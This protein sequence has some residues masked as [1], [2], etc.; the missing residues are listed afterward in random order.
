MNHSVRFFSLVLLFLLIVVSGFS[1]KHTRGIV[2]DSISLKTLP[3]VHV[4]FKNK[5][6]GTTT[7]AQGVFNL[8]T[9]P[10][11]TLI[12]TY[13]GFNTLELPLLFEEED[14]LIRISEKAI[15]LEEI[16]ITGN[17]ILPSTIV[18]TQ[19]TM[20]TATMS[21]GQAF[22]SPIDYFSKW[23]KEKRKLAKFITENDRIRT[24]VDVIN[25]ELLRENIRY[26]HDLSEDEY[27]KLLVKFNEQNRLLTYSND[28]IEIADALQA[29]FRKNVK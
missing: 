24:Y 7:N 25:D 13:I 27:Y 23:Q 17:R 6:G 22:S 26:E 29:F 20:P 11:D 9:S 18:R 3:G 8:A 15:L 12:L 10:A 21:K 2:I 16:T 28:P 5:S 14:I 4:R 1:Q 19:R